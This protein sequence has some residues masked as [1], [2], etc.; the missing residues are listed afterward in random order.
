MSLTKQD[1]A[2]T[3]VKETNLT[4]TEALVLTNEFFDQI[5]QQL[6]KGKNVKLSSFGNFILREKSERPGRNPKT[7]EE[8]MI[9]ARKVVT[10][11]A[12]PKLKK[13]TQEGS[14]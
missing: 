4:Q 5:T 10:F 12:G 8:V 9:S 7:G 2:N 1:I 13:A 3:L 6:G 11:K 14:K